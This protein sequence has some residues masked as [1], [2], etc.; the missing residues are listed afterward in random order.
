M[1]SSPFAQWGKY[2]VNRG[3]KLIPIHVL[4]NGQCSCGQGQTCIDKGNAGKHPATRDW[5][6]PLSAIQT[7]LQVERQW[8]DN[9]ALQ[10]SMGL[11][12]GQPSKTW[13]LDIDPRNG[14]YDSLEQLESEIGVMP[15]TLRARTG[16]GG[17]HL[18]FALPAGL[19]LK[20]GPLH[21]DLPGIDVQ[22]ESAQIVL[23][24]SVHRSGTRYTWETPVDTPLAFAPEPLINLIKGS[25][26]SS[27]GGASGA[28]VDLDKLMK[29]GVPDGERNN[30]MYKVACKY[31]RQFGVDADEKKMLVIG[32]V[33]TFNEEFVKPPL[34]VDELLTL[35]RSAIDFISANPATKDIDPAVMDWLRT[36]VETDEKRITGGAAPVHDQE[37]KPESPET[38]DEAEDDVSHPADDS[39]PVVQD[40]DALPPPQEDDPNA[41][42]GDDDGG[43]P[44]APDPD[45]LGDDGVVGGRSETD[46]GNARRLIDYFGTDMRYTPGL[47]WFYWDSMSW[48]HDDESLMMLEKAKMLPAYIVGELSNL[49]M[50]AVSTSTLMD[51]ANKSKDSGGI[52]KAVGLSTSD[53]RS[54]VSVS[55]WDSDDDWL[56]VN[57]GVVNLKTGQLMPPDRMQYITKRTR[58][59]YNPRHKDTRFQIF[60]EQVTGG[61]REFQAWLQKVVGYTLTGETK[62]QKFFLVYGPPGSGKSTIL[63]IV[64][65]MLGEYSFSVPSEYIVQQRSGS[66]HADQYTVAEFQGRRMLAISELPEAELMREDAVKRL[67]GGDTMVG[68]RVAQQP[69]SFQSKG[70]LWIATNHRP[71]VKDPGVWRRMKAVPFEH[72]PHVVDTTLKP[73]LQDPNG[74]LPGVMAWAVEGAMRWYAS[75][76]G[77]GKCT[78]VD[79]ATDEY[80]K[81]EDEMGQFLGEEMRKGEGISCSMQEVHS[82]YETWCEDRGFRAG[83]L[84]RLLRSLGDRGLDITGTGRRAILNGW[85]LQPRAVAPQ[86]DAGGWGQALARAR[87]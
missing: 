62:E 75:R 87:Y 72:T 58:I 79:E 51:W 31:A 48:R 74:G 16:G 29:E 17:M 64:Q 34:E 80:R 25:R 3:W 30:T 1:T 8:G 18:F 78:V 2:Y 35:T 38:G 28:G 73:Y 76:D 22:A 53:P 81:N 6:N 84:T 61:D 63:E 12:C 47:G 69:F 44:T 20:K 54:H 33:R 50:A 59:D 41:S 67:T 27:G 77:I 43:A 68:R 37:S 49:P 42:S 32:A 5:N 40:E 71:R 14:G 39:T 56:G 36:K 82:A 66:N 83:P 21:K 24:P 60:L 86:A 57:N 65:S 13:V 26:G 11:L 45:S 85:A 46:L 15:E 52:R 9:V 7:P 70:K 4:V 10:Y 55:K 23:P 19:I